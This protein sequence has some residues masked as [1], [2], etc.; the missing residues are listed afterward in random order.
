MS[1]EA[2]SVRYLYSSL[3]KIK[4]T[5]KGT[6]VSEARTRPWNKSLRTSA[7]RQLKAEHGFVINRPITQNPKLFSR[8]FAAKSQ[9]SPLSVNKIASRTSLLF[10]SPR[11]LM[12]RVLFGLGLLVPNMG[13]CDPIRRLQRATKHLVSALNWLD[14]GGIACER[15]ASNT[16]TVL[17]CPNN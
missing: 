13:R 11:F 8:L 2:R 17:Q 6:F 16:A 9:I 1:K 7:H 12:L 14:Q 15:F 5:N 4:R 10:T 3:M